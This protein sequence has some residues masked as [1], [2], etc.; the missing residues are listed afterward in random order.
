MDAGLSSLLAELGLGHHATA[1]EEEAI[2]E[3]SLL[4]SMG[5]EMLVENLEELELPGADVTKLADALFPPSEPAAEPSGGAADEAEPQQPTLEGVTEVN[6]TEDDAS[7]VEA[8]EWV[9]NPLSLVDASEYVQAVRKLLD[10]GNA[11]MRL[12]QW[13]N[14]RAAYTRGIALEVPNKRAV[15]A[16]YYNRAA[17]QRQLQQPQLALRD[18]QTACE[19]D[20]T[21]LKAWWRAADAAL[22]LGDRVSAE[23]AV[24]AGLKV[25]P[26]CGPLLQIKLDLKSHEV[27]EN[28][29]D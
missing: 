25:K 9:L 23:E 28:D 27:V 12:K 14:A 18:A 29:L 24:V 16:F 1:L 5:R 15:C 6:M 21:N 22:A 3:L 2:T 10:E 7:A 4:Q 26:T 20:P 8:A 13:A 19:L 11:F 17:C